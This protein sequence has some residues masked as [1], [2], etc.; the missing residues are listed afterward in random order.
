VCLSLIA[1]EDF[2]APGGYDKH[3]VRN[4]TASDFTENSPR[5]ERLF[6]N[7]LVYT[8]EVWHLSNRTDRVKTQSYNYC[9]VYIQN[10]TKGWEKYKGRW[11]SEFSQRWRCWDWYSELWR[12][13]DFTAQ[14]FTVDMQGEV[15][16]CQTNTKMLTCLQ[17]SPFLTF[18]GLSSS[19]CNG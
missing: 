5:L 13:V 14:N 10:V 15:L 1:L 6:R 16:Q 11:D 18:N 9:A 3:D 4:R 17:K 2:A 8:H 19:W 12:H 7:S